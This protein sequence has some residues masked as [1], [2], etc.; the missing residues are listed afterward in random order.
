VK[1]RGKLALTLALS[2][3]PITLLVYAAGAWFAHTVAIEAMVESARDQHAALQDRCEN[4]HVRGPRGRRGRRR[5][6][7]RFY[8]EDLSPSMPGFRPLEPE[9]AEGL[10]AADSASHVSANGERRVLA[11]RV[12]VGRCSVI[13]MQRREPAQPALGFLLA[14]VPA[15]VA[16]FIALLAAGPMVRRIRR[17]R[18]AVEGAASIQ[19]AGDDEIAELSQVIQADRAA[20]QAQVEALAKRDAALSRY[21]ANTMHDVMIPL[22]VLQGHL[23]NLDEV[24]SGED[25]RRALEESHYIAS[26]LQNLSTAARLE[27]A[28]P[29]RKVDDV[30]LGEL[31][32]RVVARHAPI[33]RAKRIALN[34]AVPQEALC[35]TAD[36]TLI[37]RA[38]SNLVHN[39]VRHGSKGGHVAVVLSAGTRWEFKVLDD[40]PGVSAEDL[41]KLGE[42]RFRSD[43]AR[44]RDPEGQGLGITIA[45]EVA[46]HHQLDLLFERG[47]GPDDRPG[48]SA[49]LR[50]RLPTD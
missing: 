39:A 1:L 3:I 12:G 8:D 36:P 45:R 18:R 17:L 13:V 42:P 38:M 5:A 50:Q 44:S 48:L 27:G 35:I 25:S 43:E 11:L 16:A 33:A 22:T 21:V 37:E 28:I 34:H 31:V 23:I 41:G 19:E 32:E 6:R 4:G 10:R 14:L 7:V 29:V 46:Q 40:G 24:Q 20:L 47:D 30:D 26:L 49:T 9:L 2:V 15:L